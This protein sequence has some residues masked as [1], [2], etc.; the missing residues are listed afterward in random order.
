MTMFRW[1]MLFVFGVAALAA[2]QPD[3]PWMQGTVEKYCHATPADVDKL[4]RD[5]PEKAEHISLCA[6]QVGL[7]SRV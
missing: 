2:Q 5:Y 6:C 1:L 7:R 3:R 4:K